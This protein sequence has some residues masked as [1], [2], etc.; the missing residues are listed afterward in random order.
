MGSI[1]VLRVERAA[2]GVITNASDALWWTLA[3][4]ST[5]GFGDLY[6]IT[7]IG[8]GIGIVLMVVGIG[9]FGTFTGLV[10]SWILDEEENLEPGP[11]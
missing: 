7:D 10:A 2:G 1:L 4:M 3:T 11:T 5:A 8:R 6:P 9:L